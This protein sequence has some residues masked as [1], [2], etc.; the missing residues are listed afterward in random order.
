MPHVLPAQRPQPGG[1]E[2]QLPPRAPAHAQQVV[3][4]R[5]TQGKTTPTQ[6]TSDLIESQLQLDRKHFATQHNMY[7]PAQ[8]EAMWTSAQHNTRLCGRQ[9]STTRGYVDVS[10]AQHEAMWTSAQHNTRLC[11]RQS[12]T[13]RGYVDVSPAQH[14]AMWTSVQHNTRLCGCQS[15]SLQ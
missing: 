12:S 13:T 1:L 2:E 3:H 14:E 10:P 5:H 15:S 6:L 11:G 7:S 4:Q 9:S 8:H